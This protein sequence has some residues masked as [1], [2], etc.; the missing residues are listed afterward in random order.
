L[1]LIFTR[2]G[3]VRAYSALRDEP[4]VDWP[5]PGIQQHVVFWLNEQ[6]YSVVG[7]DS[8]KDLMIKRKGEVG[9]ETTLE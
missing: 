2:L 9:T 5:V 7:L 4:R 8:S 1:T 6:M 3:D